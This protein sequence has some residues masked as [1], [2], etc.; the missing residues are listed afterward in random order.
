MVEAVIGAAIAGI[1]ALGYVL[2]VQ[3]LMAAIL[4]LAQFTLA[5]ARTLRA[6][7]AEPPRPRVAPVVIGDRDQGDGEAPRVQVG[8]G[9]A[10]WD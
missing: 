8:G 3:A 2:L 1:V 4:L 7:W 9:L 10:R 5:Q 6:M